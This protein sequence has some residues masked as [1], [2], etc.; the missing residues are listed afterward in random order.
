MPAKT[1]RKCRK[2]FPLT[3]HP[4]GERYKRIN[5]KLEYFGADKGAAMERHLKSA[6]ALDAGRNRPISVEEEG[7][8]VK[9]LAG[10][11][12]RHGSHSEHRWR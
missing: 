3:P 5:G 6:A 9:G 2:R 11:P 1:K 8:T 4:T 12:G 7:V 10:L